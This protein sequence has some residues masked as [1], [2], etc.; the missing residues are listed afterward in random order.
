MH[1]WHNCLC[2]DYIVFVLM[3]QISTNVLVTHVQ[4]RAHAQRLRLQSFYVHVLKVTWAIH[5]QVNN[6][7]YILI[8]KLLNCNADQQVCRQ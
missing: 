3:F 5:V 1:D 4:T 6:Y 8:Y 2:Y 7:Y